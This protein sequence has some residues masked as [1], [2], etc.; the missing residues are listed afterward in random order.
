MKGAP[1]RRKPPEDSQT[2]DD[3]QTKKNTDKGK[4]P[5]TSRREPTSQRKQV[6]VEIPRLP[7]PKPRPKATVEEVEES[8]EESE[9]SPPRQEFNKE[10][11]FRD[12]PPLRDAPPEEVLPRKPVD[13]PREKIKIPG[14]RKPRAPRDTD[15]EDKANAGIVDAIRSIEVPIKIGHLIDSNPK[16]RR[17]LESSMLKSRRPNFVQTTEGDVLA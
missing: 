11:P 15:A 9:V 13:L 16:I 6:V 5:E 10:L 14:K 17:A 1:Q 3:S 7:K 12:V 2:A 4:A 8:D